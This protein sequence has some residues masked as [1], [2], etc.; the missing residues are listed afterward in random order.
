MATALITGASA[1]IG[2]ELAK[3]F[4][5]DKHDVVLVARRQDRLQA[6]A[7]EL[8]RTHGIRAHALACDL[9]SAGAVTALVKQLAERGLEIDFLVNNAGF[10]TLGPFSERE[11]E[12]EV[13]MIELN[14]TAVVRLTR[15]L[16]APM[17]ARRRGRILTVGSTAGFQPGPYMATYYATKAFVNSFSEALAYELRGTGVSATL[18]CPGPT[19]TEF[20]E[21]SGVAKSALFSAS[22]ANAADVART[23]Y[24]AMHA[25]KVVAIYGAVNWLGVQLL[26]IGPRAWVRAISAAL[27][28]SPSPGHGA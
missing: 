6:L 9:A 25:G 17:L 24:R 21:I 22:V 26:R 16:V 5:A 12:R 8:E 20:G 10:G 18:L 7:Q 19:L 15:E 2:S 3:L 4:A 14:V 13:A 27:N 23:G 1:G 28:R 11:L